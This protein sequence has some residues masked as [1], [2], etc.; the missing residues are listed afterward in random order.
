[1]ASTFEANKI[2]EIKNES[3]EENIANIISGL[4][5]RSASDIATIKTRLIAPN[6]EKS[7]VVPLSLLD[8][9][10]DKSLI[11]SN[12]AKRMEI[13][14]DKSKITD[15]R[16]IATE[17]KS[18]GFIDGLGVSIYDDENEKVIEDDFLVIDSKK[19]FV[20]LGISW[21]DRA[22]A[23]LDFKS[24]VMRIPI[25]QRKNIIVPMFVHRRKVDVSILNLENLNQVKKK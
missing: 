5:R 10:S 7:L 2:N 23:T 24:R 17:T 12:L 3:N 19:D 22:K 1:M 18:I 25:S 6:S 13:E 20:L 14:I 8:S 15:L 9:C 16:G 21:L 11:S 4:G